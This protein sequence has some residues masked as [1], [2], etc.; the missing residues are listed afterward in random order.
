MSEGSIPEGNMPEAASGS[1]S[2]HPPEERR[3]LLGGMH[4]VLFA[5]LSLVAVFFLY[6]IVA[7]GIVLIIAGGKVTE[8][9]VALMRWTTLI[10]QL[11]FILVPT[12]LLV[13]LR[14]NRVREFLRLHIPDVRDLVAAVVAVFALQQMLVGYMALQD[15]IPL[16]DQLQRFL[17][18]IKKLFEESYRLLLVAHSPWELAGVI[19]VVALTPALSEE[20]LFR[21]LVQRSLEHV[22][23]P[24]RGAILTGLIFG[25]Y[26]LLPTSVVPLSVLGIFFGFLVFRT[27][28][29][30]VAMVAH[31]VNNLIACVAVYLQVD[32]D[33]VA[34]VPS[35]NASTISMIGNFALFAVV[36]LAATLY[37]V[38]RTRP[39][40]SHPEQSSQIL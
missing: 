9:N 35:G 19:V 34:L 25:C 36:F 18:T 16:P 32:E 7:G 29:I 6:Q 12:L 2:G 11:L 33:F 21:G 31:F 37:L 3:T 26:H 30:T 39:P 10:G 5:F 14:V 38:H 24:W 4:P 28:N 22:A 40:D 27:G 17:D 15:L 20:L 1:I 13:R 23:G 8:D